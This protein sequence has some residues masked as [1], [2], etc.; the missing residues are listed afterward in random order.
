ML[1]SGWTWEGDPDEPFHPENEIAAENW[2]V[3]FVAR[4]HPP[5]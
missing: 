4:P 5:I 2:F 1:N 3:R